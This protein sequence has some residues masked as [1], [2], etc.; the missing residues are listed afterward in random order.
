[1]IYTYKLR[2]VSFFMFPFK[3][4]HVMFRLIPSGT[5]NRFSPDKY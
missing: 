5:Y 3:N 1:M 4:Q 2:F